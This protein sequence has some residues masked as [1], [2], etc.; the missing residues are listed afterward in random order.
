MK[1]KNKAKKKLNKKYE[2]KNDCNM[3]LSQTPI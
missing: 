1:T 3:T 2:Y